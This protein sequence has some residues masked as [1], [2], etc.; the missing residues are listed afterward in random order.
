MSQSNEK[1][2]VV[3]SSLVCTNAVKPTVM[4][5]A[6]TP[7]TSP[8]IAR[9]R[10]RLAAVLVARSPMV[11][12]ITASTPGTCTHHQKHGIMPMI[13]STKP[14]IAKPENGGAPPSGVPYATYPGGTG[15]AAG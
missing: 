1:P 11:L 14:A 6:T 12:K 2:S 5:I 10:P 4:R 8:A 3:Q 9:P 7:T 15:G 13:A